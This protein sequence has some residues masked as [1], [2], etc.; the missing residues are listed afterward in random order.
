MHK[1]MAHSTAYI[2]TFIQDE[3]R[4]YFFL[5][6]CFFGLMV[7]NFSWPKMAEML[8]EY[9]LYLGEQ[10]PDPFPDDPAMRSHKNPFA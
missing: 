7:L 3:K 2:H 4:V 6:M 10:M 9:M 1:L 8:W 5:M